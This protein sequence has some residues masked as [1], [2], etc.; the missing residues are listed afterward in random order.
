MILWLKDNS[1]VHLLTGHDTQVGGL[2][3]AGW[4][5][6]SKGKSLMYD[7]MA[8]ALQ[9]DETIIHSFATYI[10]LVSIEGSTLLAPEGDH[11]DRADAYALA[12]TAI[13]GVRQEMVQTIQSTGLWNGRS[14]NGIVPAKGISI[15][16]G[17]K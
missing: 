5:S 9:Y 4:L 15:W 10:Q 13:R 12:I 8:D 14:S 11:D 6:S 3:K 1:N 2:T 17:R 7:A 16:Q